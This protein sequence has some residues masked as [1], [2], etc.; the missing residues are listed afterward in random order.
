MLHNR[1]PKV[2]TEGFHCS[3]CGASIPS[4]ETEVVRNCEG[5]FGCQNRNATNSNTSC[6]EA[7]TSHDGANSFSWWDRLRHVMSQTRNPSSTPSPSFTT[8]F[9]AMAWRRSFL[10][11]IAWLFANSD[12]MYTCGLPNEFCIAVQRL[13]PFDMI[14]KVFNQNQAAA[15]LNGSGLEK[16]AIEMPKSAPLY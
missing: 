13:G 11:L 5:R 1:L 4:S 16:L 2:C 8:W 12:C 10:K 14:G 7:L 6:W 15:K 9:C 3:D